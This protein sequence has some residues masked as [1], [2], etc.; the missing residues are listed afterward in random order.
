MQKEMVALQWIAEWK[1]QLSGRQQ[2]G[3]AN[4][5]PQIIRLRTKDKIISIAMT[6]TQNSSTVTFEI[7]YTILVSQLHKGSNGA[8]T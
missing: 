7:L 6:F 4:S 2:G 3:K 5:M 8:Y 1:Q